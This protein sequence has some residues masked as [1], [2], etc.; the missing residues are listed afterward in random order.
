MAGPAPVF[1][2]IHG[3]RTFIH[4]LEEQLGRLPRT[5]KAKQANLQ[6][7]TDAHTQAVDTIKSLKVTAATC[8]KSLKSKFESIAR[9]E[10]QLGTIQSK[11][12]YDAKQLEIAFA[13]TECSKL[14]EQALEAMEQAETL[15]GTV[16]ELEKALARARD[17]LSVFEKELEGKRATWTAELERAKANLAE[18]ETRLPREVKTTYLRTV[19]SMGHEGFAEVAGRSCG[20]CQ[21][22]ITMQDRYTL[23]GDQFL[24]CNCGRIL[25]LPETRPAR[26]EDES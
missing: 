7:H 15:A 10:E 18:A 12:E 19:Q 25:Y 13:K 11:K 14:E 5:L 2:E 24:M 9:Y 17:E 21:G 3:L 1:R 22:D 23:E 6:R 16:P 20:G 26:E 4:D 8:E